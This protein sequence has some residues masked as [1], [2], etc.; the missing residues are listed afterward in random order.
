[1]GKIVFFLFFI[2][3]FSNANEGEWSKTGH[4]TV[5][6]VAEQHLSKKTRKALKKLLNGRDLA[7]VS[8]FGD[9]IKADRAFKEFSA[10]H[11]VNIPDGKRYSDI[12]PNK[13]GDIVVG[14]QKCVEIIKDPNAKREDKVFYL[15][16]LVHLIGDLHQPLHVGRFEDKGGND[17]QLQWFN[18]GSN[19]H[20]VWDSNMINDY[21]MSYT[22]LASSLPKLSK[23]QIKQ[24][25]EGTIYDWVGESQDIAQQLYGSV[26]AG[27]KLYYRYSYDWWGTV[28][29]QLQKGGLRLAKVLNGLF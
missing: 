6:E 28:E 29:D 15:K 10:W 16:M 14:I 25:Q 21:G 2:T 18:K 5:G 23:K 20:K 7:Y 22:E 12:E 9:D 8:T 13:H 4:R 26:E 1:M 11:Y 17:I 3:F 24:I 19:L 27:E